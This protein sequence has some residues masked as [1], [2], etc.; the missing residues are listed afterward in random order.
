MLHYQINA[1]Q[2][3]IDKAVTVMD[4]TFDITKCGCFWDAL[5]ANKN[6]KFCNS[7]RWN[8]VANTKNYKI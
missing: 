6:K 4:F 7:K 3:K 1:V 5:L 2:H 8:K